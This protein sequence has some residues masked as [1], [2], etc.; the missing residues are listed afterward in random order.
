MRCCI[1]R[2]GV[3]RESAALLNGHCVKCK[4]QAYSH[5]KY[6]RGVCGFDGTVLIMHQSQLCTSIFMYVLLFCIAQRAHD[7]CQSQQQQQQAVVF[8]SSTAIVSQAL[9]CDD[10]PFLPMSNSP[11]APCW[12]KGSQ[13]QHIFYQVCTRTKI[14]T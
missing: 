13:H 9:R 12:T 3:R 4:S 8:S 14:G 2:R 6:L 7:R 1:A 11:V 5:K 10:A